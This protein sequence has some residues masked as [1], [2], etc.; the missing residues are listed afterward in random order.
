MRALR[1]S[2]TFLLSF[3]WSSEVTRRSLWFL[4][5]C[6]LITIDSDTATKLSLACPKSFTVCLNHELASSFLCYLRRRIYFI[7]ARC[8]HLPTVLPRCICLPTI[9]ISHP[10]RSASCC[11]MS[12]FLG[13]ISHLVC[14]GEAFFGLSALAARVGC[15]WTGACPLNLGIKL[16]RNT[17][18]S[19]TFRPG[20][21]IRTT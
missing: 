1:F 3:F 21:V 19:R 7:N 6:H 9:F 15:P 11:A 13:T 12:M 5:T 4:D 8:A 10:Q 16:S 18:S 14:L 17:R 20:P 2:R